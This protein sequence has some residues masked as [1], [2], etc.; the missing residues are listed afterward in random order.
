MREVGVLEAKTSFTSLIAEV[1]RTG[2]EILVT[3]RGRAAVK[4]VPA[5]PQRQTLSPEERKAVAEKIIAWRDA[6]PIDPTLADMSWDELKP[7]V[8]N[9]NRYD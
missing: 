1:E 8:R 9:E 5:M 6:Q 4:I 2:E 7:L 3:R